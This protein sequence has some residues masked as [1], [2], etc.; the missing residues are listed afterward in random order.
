MSTHLDRI[1]P[2]KLRV[3]EARGFVLDPRRRAFVNPARA[4]IPIENVEDHDVE[5]LGKR[6][7]EI[8][9]VP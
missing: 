6:I 1:N 7:A 3:L 9:A 8:E 2:A 5:W 4:L